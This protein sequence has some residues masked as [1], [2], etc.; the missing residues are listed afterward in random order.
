MRAAQLLHGGI[1]CCTQAVGQNPIQNLARLR[2]HAA[3]H[4]CRCSPYTAT[5]TSHC[6]TSA[7]RRCE[8][9]PRAMQKP[10]LSCSDVHCIHTGVS[11]VY[12]GQRK[13]APRWPADPIPAKLGCILCGV[14]S[15]LVSAVLPLHESLAAALCRHSVQA[16]LFPV[17]SLA[18]TMPA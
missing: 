10:G 6:Q 4:S 18:A 1:G 13:E 2:D 11:S 9:A 12:L 17:T 14:C 15:P 5:C 16:R 3:A 8:E 7:Q